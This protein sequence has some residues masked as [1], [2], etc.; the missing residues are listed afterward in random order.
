MLR[1]IGLAA[2]AIGLALGAGL[3]VAQD[4][5]GQWQGVL[6]AGKERRSIVSIT[7]SPGGEL[8]ANFYS[9][10]ESSH[11]VPLSEVSWDGST[12]KFLVP[13]I[14]ATYEGKLSDDGQKIEGTWTQGSSFQLDYERPSETN[15]WAIPPSHDVQFI[16]TDD[17]VKLEVVDWGGSGRPLLL[18]AGMGDTAHAFDLFAPKLT[19]RYRV[20]GVTRRGFGASDK[21]ELTLSNFMSDRLADDVLQV[22]GALEL[23]RPVLAG[24]SLG[25][26]ELSSIASRHPDKVAGLIYL[27]AAYAYAFYA[28]GNQF[29]IGRNLDIEAN[30]LREKIT[31]LNGVDVPPA[32]AA[33]Q[34]EELLT[35][36][37]PRLR[38]EL[39]AT[40]RVLQQWAALSEMEPFRPNALFDTIVAGAQ[41]YTDLN[42]LPTLAIYASPVALPED[43][44]EATRAYM[45]LLEVERE[46]LIKRFEQANPTARVVRLPDAEHA[47]FV[48]HPSEVLREMNAFID[49]LN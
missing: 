39:R 38:E 15:A 26:Q 46:N 4:I 25:G 43:T 10:D 17:N 27:D 21:P 42:D 3:A 28:P 22:I 48:S 12:F 40:Q 45:Q 34:I 33:E 9:I 36:D 23:D 41:K 13:Q 6:H 35:G 16:T 5:E 20:Y 49:R 7:K 44:D 37:L 11:A 18:L 47:V 14:N 29:P 19:T 1:C 8:Q 24:F 32:E 30:E 31:R 2:F